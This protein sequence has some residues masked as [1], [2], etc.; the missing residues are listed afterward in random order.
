[1]L[2]QR[3]LQKLL[4]TCKR[5]VGEQRNKHGRSVVYTPKQIVTKALCNAAS[6]GRTLYMISPSCIPELTLILD[7]YRYCYGNHKYVKMHL[8]NVLY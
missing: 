8:I 5:I 6:A 3:M 1:M 4:W 2:D 7:F